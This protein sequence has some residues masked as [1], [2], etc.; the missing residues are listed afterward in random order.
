MNEDSIC[1]SIYSILKVDNKE[2]FDP[3]FWIDKNRRG[4]HCFNGASRNR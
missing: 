3:T 1:N 4:V 2:V